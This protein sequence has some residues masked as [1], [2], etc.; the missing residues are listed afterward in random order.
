MDLDFWK[1]LQEGERFIGLGEKTGPL[2]RKG[3]GYQNWNTDSFGYGTG[4]DPLYSTIPFFIGIHH[5]LSYGIFFDNS[6][7]S[8][9]NF[10]ASNNR[11]SSFAADADVQRGHSRD[12]TP[13]R[14]R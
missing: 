7:K 4:A 5:H 9:F 1:K 11:F 14:D 12:G 3:A 8:F 10:G 6:Y 2:D 13:S